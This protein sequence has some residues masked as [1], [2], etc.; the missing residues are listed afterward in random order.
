MKRKA[1]GKGLSALLPE[2]PGGAG[3]S[4]TEVE[5]DRI[6]PNPYQPRQQIEESKL[7]ELADSLSKQ[8]LM[9]TVVVRRVGTRYQLIAGE[10]RWRAAGLAGFSRVPV[11]VRQVPE[12]QLLELALVENIQREELNPIEEA[13]AYQRMIGELGWSQEQIAERVSKDRSTVANLLRLMKLPT[14]IRTAIAAQNLSPGHA[15][16]LLAL[17]DADAQIGLARDVVE[18]GLSVREVEQRVKSRLSGS[19]AP[20]KGKKKTAAARSEPNTRAAEDRL[21]QVL[22]TR[23]RILRKG[24]S[25]TIELSYHSEEELGR[26]Y[27]IL[28]RGARGKLSSIR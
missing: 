3:S 9:Q 18:K 19:G 6:D 17:R 4:Q 24:R 23:V 21:R 20:G 2:V 22:G 5:I 10:R 7:R 26:L 14:V 12:E 25:G 28:L 1:L 8:G 27:E 11:V 15:R 16:P 13:G